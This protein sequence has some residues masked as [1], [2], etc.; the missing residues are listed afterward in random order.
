[1]RPHGGGHKAAAREAALKAAERL[2]VRLGPD[3]TKVVDAGVTQIETHPVLFQPHEFLGKAD[4]EHK[5][6]LDKTVSTKRAR[7]TTG[8]NA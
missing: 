1:M 5:M 7:A 6:P 3:D 2:V 4:T 8:R